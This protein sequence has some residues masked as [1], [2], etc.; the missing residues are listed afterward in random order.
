MSASS[1]ISPTSRPAA[2]RT[3]PADDFDETDD[4]FVDAEDHAGGDEEDDDDWATGEYEADASVLTQCELC[5]PS[6]GRL[7]LEASCCCGPRP[8]AN[9]V[10]IFVDAPAAATAAKP[11]AVRRPRN[12]FIG[13]M[14]VLVYDSRGDPVVVLGPYWMMLMFVTL[15][16][17]VLFPALVAWFW[18][19]QLHLAVQLSYAACVG[20]EL[21]ALLSTGCRDPGLVRRALTAP[22]PSWT[23]NDQARTFKPPGAR[24]CSWCECCFVDFDHTCPWTGTA[25]AG[26]NIKSFKTFLFLLQVVLYYTVAVFVMGILGF[27]TRQPG[28]TF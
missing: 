22:H 28:H 26:G 5:D 19:I 24:Y 14:L 21:A 12:R 2:S 17:A 15:P 18:C 10:P 8:A 20:L 25:I 11:A 7:L 1:S 27:A 13:N 9:G 23:W 16:M 4:D 3:T 6:F